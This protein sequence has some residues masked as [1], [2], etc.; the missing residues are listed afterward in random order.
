MNRCS[1]CNFEIDESTKFCPNCGSNCQ[2][3]GVIKCNKCGM[4][5]LSSVSFCKQ[6]GNN[7]K[8]NRS[9]EIKQKF[10]AFLEKPQAKI[11]VA[12][13]I[14]LIIV[15]ASTFYYLNFMSK[16][17]YLAYYGEASR[18]IETAND[19]LVNNTTA[20]NL[21]NEKIADLQNQ[22]QVQRDE[23]MNFEKTFSNTHVLQ[24]YSEHHKNLLALLDKEIA[25]IEET[26][27]VIGKP[28]NKETDNVI[29]SLKA[30]IE[31]AKGLSEKIKVEERNF[32]LGKG[33]TVLPHQLTMFVEEQRTINKEKIA[34]LLLMND[35]FQ[36]VDTMIQRYDSSKLDLGANLDNLRKGG[37]TWNDYF[38]TL[39][40]A[41]AFRVGLRNQIDFIKAPKGAEN[42]KRQFSEV[43]SLV[44]QYCDKMNSGAQLE[45]MYRYP[46][47]E[48]SYNEAKAINTKVQATYSDFINNYQTE[49]NRLTNMENL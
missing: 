27:L 1:S 25:M 32:D 36:K 11:G 22:L 9:R 23:L 37:Y 34:R 47:A 46:D 15:A 45:Y 4:E 30:N 12:L 6:C 35:F 43:V 28:L 33:I 21:K 16:S 41:R 13:G 19:I 3:A 5:N 10:A 8:Q 40:M 2:Q 31:E 7:L 42:V 18:K 29:D 48:K 39:E 26:K 24:E 17:H 44:I 14:L 49:K 20:E 38:N